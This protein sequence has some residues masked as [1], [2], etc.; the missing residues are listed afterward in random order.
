MNI[1]PTKNSIV[2][3]N[4]DEQ[5]KQDIFNLLESNFNIK[6]EIPNKPLLS[7]LTNWSDKIGFYQTS[8]DVT[9]YKKFIRSGVYKIWYND[10]VIYIGETRC[11]KHVNPATRPGMWARRGDFRST[12]L[13]GNTIRNPY[14]NGTSYLEKFSLDELDN[15]YH[16]FHYVHQ[17]FCKEIELELLQEYYDTHNTLPILQSEHDYKRINLK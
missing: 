17:D 5:S 2:I 6:I 7:E 12:I 3:H 11:D 16:T 10:E 13:G 14:G 4:L 1:V 9:D 8:K 15:I